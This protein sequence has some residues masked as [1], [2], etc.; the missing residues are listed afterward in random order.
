MCTVSFV[1]SGNKVWI[2]SNRDEKSTRPAALPVAVNDINGMRVLFPRDTSAMGTWIAAQ[3]YGTAAVLLNG[4][5]V[6]HHPVAGYR[7]SRGQVLLQVISRPDPAQSI[8]RFD[9]QG[10]EPFTLILWQADVLTEFRWDGFLLHAREMD[11]QKPHIW[12]SVTLYSPDIIRKRETWFREFMQRAPQVNAHSLMQFHRSAG[13]GDPEQSLLMQRGDAYATVSITNLE[14]GE[15]KSVMRYSDTQNQINTE[16]ALF[17]L[18][19][20]G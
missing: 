9:L 18:S 12:S 2:T 6:P 4:A 16:A 14:I 7:L 19:V 10:I 3:E 20:P 11:G 13:D 17:H 8:R 1:P 15:E 5:F